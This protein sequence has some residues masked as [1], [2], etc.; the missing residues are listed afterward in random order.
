MPSFDVVNKVDLQE[1]TNSVNNASKEILQRYDFKGSK[2]EIEWDD[3]E[4]RIVIRTEDEMKMEAVREILITHATRRNLDA[5]SMEFKDVEAAGGKTL[6][7]E[8][9]IREGIE[10]DMAKKMVKDVKDAKIKVQVSIQGDELRVSGKKRDDLQAVMALL[11]AGNYE[12]P[13]QFVN[14]RD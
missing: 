10:Q 5:E 14:M 4:N 11:K 3:K 8:V 6:R 9:L 12:V 2:T 7:R 13:L 1:V